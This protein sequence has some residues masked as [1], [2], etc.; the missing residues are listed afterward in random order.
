MK[1]PEFSVKRK[2][3]ASMIAMILV[4]VGLI[5]FTRLGLDF[6][7]D[8][9]YPTVSVI[10]T[11]RG[12][13]S[14]DIEKTITEPLEQVVSS[15]SGVKKVT[16]QSSEGVSVLMVEFEWG[17]NLD[18]AAQDIRDQIG[19]YRNF[20]PTNASNPLVVKFNLSQF[21]VVFYGITANSGYSTY[22]LKKLIEDEVKPRLERLDGVAS[23]VVFATDEREIRVEVDK[24][25]LISYNLALDR[26][27]LALAAEN[28]NVPAGEV[29]ERHQDLIVRTL[30]E[31]RS[32]DDVRN[33]VVGLS[34]RGE[35]I[36]LKDIAEVKDTFKET[37]SVARVQ[38]QK[39]V[40]LVVN[41]RSGANTAIVG[42]AVKKEV[43][44]IQ[45]T[46]PGNI[47]FYLAMDQAEM[48]NMVA[49]RT[50][51]NALV[52]ALL[53]IVLIFL[54]LRN[55]RP[56]LIIS[57]AIPLSIITTFVALYAAGYT[58]NLMTLGGL[59]LGVGMLV[60]NAIVVIENTFRH[61][62]EG[63][64]VEE[65]AVLGAT[66]VGMAI[67]ASTL[68]TIIVFLP[69]V[70]AGGITGKL[71]QPL[72]L[73]IVFSLVASL[74]V[75][76]TLVPLF[77]SLLFK[78]R[79]KMKAEKK[80]ADEECSVKEPRFAAA[81]AFY[82]NLLAQSLRKRKT[83]LIVTVAL[84]VVSLVSVAFIGTEFMPQSDR[85]FLM[86]RIK[87]PVGTSLEETNRVLTQVEQILRQQPEVSLVTAQAGSRAEEDPADMASGMGITGTHEGMLMVRLVDL[88]ERKYTDAEILERVRKMLPRLEN[89][90]FEQINMEAAMMGGAAAPVEIKLFGKDLEVL[91]EI[92][93]SVVKRISD[94]E[95]LRDLTH[96]LAQGKPEYQF[97]LDRERASRLGLAVASVASTIQTA[98]Q[99]T[100]V[101]RY[102]DGSDEVNIRVILAKQYRDSLEEI[103]KTPLMSP[104]GK[105]IFLDQI[106]DWQRGEG[107]IQITRE[108]QMRKISVT[109]NI[110]GRD[111][112]SVMRDIRS[113]L[114]DMEKQLPSGYFLEYGGS[115]EQ[116]IDAF[117][118]L[119]A[120]LALAIL[121]VY[122]VMASQFENFLHPFVIMFT[123]PLAIIGVIFGLLVSGK[124]VSLPALI[125]VII[126]A[127]IAVNNGIVM[128]DYINQLIRRGL[129]KREAVIKGA[130][131][132]LR[133]V[134]LT[135]LTTILGML[136]MAVSGGSGSE[137]RS[138]MAV[139]VVGGL[140]ATTLLTLF[141]IPIVY[142]IF[143]R[144]SFKDFRP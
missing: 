122:M 18:F 41:K 72:A 92:G 101:S 94:V 136:P 89:F 27:L 134:L 93:D 81:R 85:N 51:N 80:E 131:T 33:V 34:Q 17:T 37:R 111:L 75:A 109:A 3:T 63:K 59:A 98:T 142:S 38:E 116:M 70:F 139:A 44:K 56:T 14:E 50:A 24:N 79:L 47:N 112:G 13:S 88:S 8:L 26:V 1:L 130:V 99:G 61:I 22:D 54:F 29:V 125:G 68:T 76:L 45:P 11:Y 87:L 107:P 106:A 2:V 64:Q 43:S 108:N 30:G 132:R 23:A 36:Y 118:V 126:L 20:L 16:S 128:I 65:A 138:P 67:T 46:L 133:P 71:T 140:T 114:G 21:P 10:T 90:K 9:E 124:P 103:R 102:R 91:R 28:I 119:A 104:A 69:V 141:I 52:G 77:S 31:F 57:V 49:S 62:E 7:P 42:N 97:A 5:A 48:I 113:R 86:V 32:V 19:L 105:I 115:Y 4:V 78:A 66:E 100:V 25:A 144:I 123:I 39:G 55:W 129:D 84:F 110:S 95:G 82:R 53:A 120:A 96:S 35:P 58:L 137:F 143:N 135:A 12:A 60:D 83:V 127:G 117:K 6:F 121:L 74:F 73:T 40:Y 15:V